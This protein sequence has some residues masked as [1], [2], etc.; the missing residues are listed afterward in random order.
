M[1]TPTTPEYSEGIGSA[2]AG[3]EYSEYSPLKGGVNSRSTHWA[4]A[5]ARAAKPARSSRGQE[6]RCDGAGAPPV[7]RTQL[8]LF[9]LAPTA[10]QV[11]V[12]D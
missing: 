5:A 3:T 6:R 10:A 2:H 12:F 11:A 9:S 8:D 7:G 4:P 1:S